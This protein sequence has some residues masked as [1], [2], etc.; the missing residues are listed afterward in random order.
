MEYYD[1][2][3]VGAGPAA[4]TASVYASRYKIKHLIIG[5]AVGG[6]MAEAH[7]ICNYPSENEISGMELT[8]KMQAH[9]EALGAS[10]VMDKVVKIDKK[11]DNGFILTTQNS[12]QTYEARTLLLTTGTKH[13]K[14]NLPNEEKF[15][16]RGLSYCATC[17]AMFYRQKTVA[18][19][20]GSNS[21]HTAALYLA[22]VAE[23][24][25]QIYRGD[26]LRGETA[27]IDQVLA[28][29]KIEVIYQREIKELIGKEKLE[30]IRLDKPYQGQ[31][32]LAVDGLFVE[33]G[34]QPDTLLPEQLGVEL[35]QARY[36]HVQVDQSTNVKGVWAAGDVT[37]A[38]NNLRQIVTACA[39]GAI[40]AESIFK[41]IT[42][43]KK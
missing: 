18:V 1:L 12:R 43:L 32:K 30:A 36:I 27:W 13:R 4:Y 26:K 20:G 23:K 42:A 31:D 17:D 34:S 9:A 39:E 25:Y 22:E 5:E 10:L 33:V 2:I 40:A 35:D 3:I 7:K 8:Q 38:S 14:L 41:F 21:A 6:L 11:V 37:D 28:N 19:V 24:V 15:L 16:G 29:K